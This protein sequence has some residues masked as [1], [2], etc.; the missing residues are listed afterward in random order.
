MDTDNMFTQFEEYSWF[1]VATGNGV[2]D[3]SVYKRENEEYDLDN[4]LSNWF[5][6]YDN[7]INYA[8]SLAYSHEDLIELIKTNK[9]I[10]N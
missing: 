7:D 4:K 6:K 5:M 3:K 1:L 9:I 10:L 2:I 8:E